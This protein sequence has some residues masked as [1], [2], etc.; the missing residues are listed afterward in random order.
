MAFD[1]QKDVQKELQSLM[2]IRRVRLQ[3][4]ETE[5]ARAHQDERRAADEV[6]R[7]DEA[8][9]TVAR[10][11]KDRESELALELFN[12]KTS[13][14]HIETFRRQVSRL[15]QEVVEARNELEAAHNYQQ[16]AR[17]RTREAINGQRSAYRAGE[18]L[19]FSLRE[20]R[21]MDDG[22]SREYSSD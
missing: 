1:S 12:R 6:K 9:Q 8:A 10:D 19:D 20:L 14:S 7:K 18:K 2:Q 22:V 3:R 5:L 11:N 13:L 4:A 15:R 16:E 21:A 17:V